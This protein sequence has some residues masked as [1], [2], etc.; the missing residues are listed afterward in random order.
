METDPGAPSVDGGWPVSRRHWL[1]GSGLALASTALGGCGPAEP[2]V[3]V[4]ERLPFQ[5]MDLTAI[6][7]GDRPL[8]DAVRR[9]AGEWKAQTGS[10]LTVAEVAEGDPLVAENLVGDVVVYPSYRVGTLADEKFIGALPDSLI[11]GNAVAWPD[12]FENLRL[13]EATWGARTFGVPLGSASL[14][15]Y[16]RADLFRQFEKQPP[17]TWSDY[18]SLAE[19]FS[20]RQRLGDAAPPADQPWHGTLEPL[21]SPWGGLVLLARGAAY[22]KH[23][24]HYSATFHLESMNPLID[25]PPFV[26]ALEE[27]VA[28][29]MHMPADAVQL[30][31]ADVRRAFWKGQSA[32]GLSWP[33]A[34]SAV[35]TLRVRDP[36]AEVGFAALPGSREVYQP[37]GGFWDQRGPTE[38]T[39][40]PLL[41]A[42]GRLA[43]TLN[44]SRFPDAAQ[45]L[46]VFLATEP[47]CNQISPHSGSTTLFRK[48]QLSKPERWTEEEISPAAARDYARVLQETLGQLHT[49][50]ALRLPGHDEY[51]AALT[52]AV[53]TSVSRAM[54]PREALVEAAKR[55]REVTDGF[56]A[57]SQRRSYQRSLGI[58]V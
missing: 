15:L 48:S 37:G 18:A 19:F 10:E 39:H 49:L 16:Y 41:G 58:D 57:S 25:G 38:S 29:T 17:E 11:A 56:Q 52:K 51:L 32:L 26:R 53:H 23:R 22:A 24:D 33:S 54:P 8:A 34:A 9:V 5:G 4:R 35:N 46:L 13:R 44:I 14:V 2:T 28:A 45:Q 7:V 40:V 31:P 1:A 50:D 3:E 30:N 47:W 27:L 21:G 42:C 55:W 6:V 36:R 20:D 12:L 43:S